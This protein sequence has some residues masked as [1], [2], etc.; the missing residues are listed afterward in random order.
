MV[1]A[2]L[3]YTINMQSFTIFAHRFDHGGFRNAQEPGACLENGRLALA[4][5][6]KSISSH[7]GRSDFKL[8]VEFDVQQYAWDDASDKDPVVLHDANFNRVLPPSHGQR[9]RLISEFR[10]NELTDLEFQS[11]DDGVVFLSDVLAKP[12]G[13]IN[14]ELKRNPKVTFEE[15]VPAVLTQIRSSIKAGWQ[16]SDAIVVSS[17]DH[18]LLEDF[19]HQ[20]PD[21]KTAVLVHSTHSCLQDV[22]TENEHAVTETISPILRRCGAVTLNIDLQLCSAKL[23]SACHDKGWQVNVF[24]IRSQKDFQ[25]ALY[26]GADGAFVDHFSDRIAEL[27]AHRD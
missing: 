8:G 10:R 12:L 3:R 19:N 7:L 21:I 9:D 11:P 20:A 27:Q 22:D 16:K 17:F 13:I 1:K 26:S 5:A 23:V 6:S 18:D 25:K 4:R 2:V 15:L 24:T 14:I